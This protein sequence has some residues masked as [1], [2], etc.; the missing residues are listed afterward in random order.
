QLLDYLFAFLEDKQMNNRDNLNSLLKEELNDYYKE[1]ANYISEQISYIFFHQDLYKNTYK[2][3]DEESSLSDDYDEED[4]KR[5]KLNN[6][7]S[8][9]GNVISCDKID[10]TTASIKFEK[11]ESAK[12]ALESNEKPFK[13]NQIIVQ[14]K[15]SPVPAKPAF[16]FIKNDEKQKLEEPV[17]RVKNQLSECKTANDVNKLEEHELLANNMY[18]FT[19]IVKYEDIQNLNM[20]Q[21]RETMLQHGRVEHFKKNVKENSIEVSYIEYASAEKAYFQL[22]NELDIS[23]IRSHI[24]KFIQQPQEEEKEVEDQKENEQENQGQ[25]NGE[26]CLQ[27]NG[28]EEQ[29]IDNKHIF[30]INGQLKDDNDFDF[31]PDYNDDENEQQY[32]KGQD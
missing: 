12:R 7:F 25:Q 1:D 3:I 21:F 26:H 4:D 10:S 6:V 22:Q 13:R 24:L 14:Q 20:Q 27:E 29:Q 30:D 31:D 9:F 8:K 18:D 16:Q 5:R 11:E 28:Q 23:F 32:N 19:L 2:M 17:K 15:R